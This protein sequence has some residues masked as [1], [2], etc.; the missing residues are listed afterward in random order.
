MEVKIYAGPTLEPIFVVDASYVTIT[1]PARKS[2]LAI[3]WITF[4]KAATRVG[5]NNLP[6]S[7][8]LNTQDKALSISEASPSSEHFKR[9]KEY[10]KIWPKEK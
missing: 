2:G 10:I 7:A 3:E 1:Y 4:E 5:L 9:Y 6:G 8:Y